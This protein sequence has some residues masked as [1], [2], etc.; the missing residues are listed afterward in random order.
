M[1]NVYDSRHQ[2]DVRADGVDA[3]AFTGVHHGQLARH[4]ENGTLRIEKA[5]RKD[6]LLISMAKLT[7]RTRYLRGGVYA[8][9]S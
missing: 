2:M 5:E 4:R 8:S 9:P 6:E 3:D 1:N 7:Q